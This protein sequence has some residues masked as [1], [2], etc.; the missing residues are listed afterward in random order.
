[1]TLGEAKRKVLM[2]IDEYSSGG[3]IT[4]DNDI[5]KKMADFFDIAQKKICNIKPIV[6]VFIPILVSDVFEYDLPH[7]FKKV[8]RIWVDGRVFNNFIIIGGKIKIPSTFLN[9]QIEIEYIA[10]PLT[11]DDS[12]SD[13]YVFQVVDDCAECLPYYVA[14]QQLIV[15]LVVD[16][17]PLMEMYDRMVSELDFDVGLIK[18]SSIRQSFYR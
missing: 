6:K 17:Q 18:Q 15:D 7:D 8:F 4:V 9:K 5:D 11:I 10:N 14:A 2:L 13:D 3:T 12:A 16:Y 1:M